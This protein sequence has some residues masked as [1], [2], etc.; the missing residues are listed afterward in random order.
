MKRVKGDI[1]NAMHGIICHQVNCQGAMGSGLARQIRV[2]YPAVFQEYAKLIKA[3]GK[4]ECLGKCQ[5]ITVTPKTLYVANLFGQYT[6]GRASKQYTDYGAL[7]ASMASLAQW[8]KENCHPNFP[9][10]IPYMIGCGLGGGRW[11]EV[12]AIIGNHLPDSIVV[13]LEK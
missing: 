3:W 2:K 7:S 11:E 8:Y 13:R 4:K 1:L 5:I 12:E 9:V 10:F 6:Y